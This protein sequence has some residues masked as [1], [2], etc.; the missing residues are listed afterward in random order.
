MDCYAR[1]RNRI[2]L[3]NRRLLI[4]VL[5]VDSGWSTTDKRTAHTHAAVAYDLLNLLSC[6]RIPCPAAT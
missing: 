1:W 2:S 6:A 4:R 3:L 5:N